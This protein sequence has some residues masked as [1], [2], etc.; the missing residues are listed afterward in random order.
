MPYVPFFVIVV[1][2]VSVG[3]G[4]VGPIVVVP[5]GDDATNGEVAAGVEVGAQLTGMSV[6]VAVGAVRVGRVREREG[7]PES[8]MIPGLSGLVSACG[9][10]GY[11]HFS[12][13]HGEV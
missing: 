10:I 3:V 13:G 5:C 9:S 1:C 2:E 12:E 11:I 6:G 8:I 4:T 7:S